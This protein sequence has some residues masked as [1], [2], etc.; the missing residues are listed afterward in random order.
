MC[1]DP[2]KKK[3]YDYTK[4]QQEFKNRFKGLAVNS[5]DLW[6]SYF[7]Y[8][9]FM[10]WSANINDLKNLVSGN[11]KEDLESKIETML[12]IVKNDS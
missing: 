4:I 12:E 11:F 9:Y 10:N 8:R 6:V 7:Y 2:E 1:I 5:S 3:E